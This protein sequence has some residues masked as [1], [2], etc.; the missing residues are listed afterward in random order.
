MTEIQ[1][2]HIRARAEQCFDLVARGAGGTQGRN[3]LRS[4]I[5]AHRPIALSRSAVDEDSA[6][7]VHVRAGRAGADQAARRGEYRPRIVVAKPLLRVKP[8]RA[9]PL[10]GFRIQER[11]GVVLGP[12]YA[13]G[14]GGEGMYTFGAIQRYSQR[15]QEFDIST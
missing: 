8:F 14:I 15:Q 1:A 10:Q 12:V 13:I 6:E 9:Y 3:D 11:S 2:E 7:V 5:A 4:A